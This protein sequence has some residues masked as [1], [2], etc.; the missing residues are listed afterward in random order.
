MFCLKLV[1][2]IFQCNLS[3]AAKMSAFMKINKKITKNAYVRTAGGRI[4]AE[5]VLRIVTS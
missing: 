2:L 1:R 5:R 3:V 4:K